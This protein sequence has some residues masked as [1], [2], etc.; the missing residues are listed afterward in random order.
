VTS[1]GDFEAVF[2]I[3][4]RAK[5][6]SVAGLARAAARISTDAPSGTSGASPAHSFVYFDLAAHMKYKLQKQPDEVLEMIT[7]SVARA[8]PRRRCRMVGGGWNKIEI[9]FLCRCVEA[10]IKAGATTIN[11]P[12]TV[13]YAVPHEYRALFEMCA[14]KCPIR[15]RR[16]FPCIATMIWVLPRRQYAGRHRRRRAP[17]RM[18]DQRH[19]RAGRQCRHGR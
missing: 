9:E 2:A 12:D 7:S 14:K 17:S 18:H 16:S 1:E 10:A 13:G 19:G 6:A 15:T 4:K 5:R 8:W 11:I 3:A